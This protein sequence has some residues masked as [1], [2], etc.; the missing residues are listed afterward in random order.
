VSLCSIRKVNSMALVK[1]TDDN[2]SK[3]DRELLSGPNTMWREPSFRGLSNSTAPQVRRRVSNALGVSFGND[4]RRIEVGRRDGVVGHV[5][6]RCFPTT[7]AQRHCA[8][9]SECHNKRRSTYIEFNEHTKRCQESETQLKLH[10]NMAPQLGATM[11]DLES[12]LEKLVA[13]IAVYIRTFGTPSTTDH[14]REVFEQFPADRTM[15][16]EPVD[17]SCQ[18]MEG[19]QGA[20]SPPELDAGY[21]TCD[22]D[23]SF[24]EDYIPR[25]SSPAQSM[26]D[27]LPMDIDGRFGSY[28]SVSKNPKWSEPQVMHDD[29]Q[30]DYTYNYA[31]AET[32]QSRFSWDSSDYSDASPSPKDEEEIVWWKTVKPLTVR[33]EAPPIPTKNP[34]RLLRRLSNSAPRA[35][36]EDTRA[37]RNILNL[38]LDLSRLNDDEGPISP[39]QTY[40]ISRTPILTQEPSHVASES[41]LSLALP[42][43]ILDAM[44]NAKLSPEAWCKV[45][46]KRSRRSPRLGNTS[47]THGRSRSVQEAVGKSEY[48][49]QMMGARGHVRGASDPFPSRGVRSGNPS[50][51]NESMP[52]HGCIRRSCIA[53]LKNEAKPRP[54]APALAINKQLPPLPIT[55]DSA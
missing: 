23:L 7:A 11:D 22:S 1:S 46:R 38:Q 26:L 9:C 52:S 35:F 47:T 29:D 8:T 16:E 20:G 34:R 50:K 4:G 40:T 19:M 48:A 43:H 51:W 54:A 53:K 33:K 21:Q 15:T 49:K 27:A 37:S 55:L 13:P 39:R 25:H 45:S 17:M 14:E 28:Y 24:G 36:S 41:Q 32:I 30:M 18:N 3:D 12:E 42:D 5:S 44:R 6:D 10:D 31:P 2:V